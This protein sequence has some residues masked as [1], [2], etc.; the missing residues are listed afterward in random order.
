MTS[1]GIPQQPR[2]PFVSFGKSVLGDAGRRR[3]PAG[4]RAPPPPDLRRRTR[5]VLPNARRCGSHRRESADPFRQRTISASIENAVGGR[6][7]AAR[8]ASQGIADRCATHADRQRLQLAREVQARAADG[9][10]Q[11]R[12]AVQRRRK[13]GR[14]VDH[15]RRHGPPRRRASTSARRPTARR[16]TS[17]AAS[18][19]ITTTRSTCSPTTRRTT[20]SCSASVSC[21]SASRSATNLHEPVRVAGFFFKSWSFRSRRAHAAPTI[22]RSDEMRQFAPLVIGRSPVVLETANSKASASCGL[23]R[24]R[25]VRAV[26]GGRSGL[27]GWWLARE[28]S[29]IRRA[30]LANRFSLPDGES[31]ND[32]DFDVSAR[33]ATSRVD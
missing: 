15:A 21:R 3:R 5:G 10:L 14:R 8:R 13:P 6:G 9:R 29:A 28:R 31:L 11:R 26:V 12:A 22:A 30:T 2:E 33:H 7:T 32:L 24:G 27:A 20:R 17:P 18:A 19:S 4:R 25:T 1:P 23:F 16:A